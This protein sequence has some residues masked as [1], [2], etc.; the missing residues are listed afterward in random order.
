MKDR[1]AEIVDGKRTPV[2]VAKK[3]KSIKLNPNIEAIA[4]WPRLKIEAV[5]TAL[6]DEQICPE[7]NIA[8]ATQI[9]IAMS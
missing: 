2:A 9:S 3:R 7:D 5:W 1:A 8:A 4:M 6:M